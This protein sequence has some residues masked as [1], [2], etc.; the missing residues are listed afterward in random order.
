M[1][2]T[3]EQKDQFYKEGVSRF[4]QDRVD[5]F[6]KQDKDDYHRIGTA[7]SNETGHRPY[8]SQSTNAAEQE[9]NRRADE[10]K[11]RR[12][13]DGGHPSDV[14]VRNQPSGGGGG[15][16][17]AGQQVINSWSQSDTFTNAIAE[18]N[19]ILREVQASEAARRA[20]IAAK[21]TAQAAKRDELY[22]QLKTRAG[23]STQISPDDQIIKSQVDPYRAEQER[24]RRNFISDVAEAEGPLGNIRGEERMAS[25]RTGINTANFQAD[26]QVRELSARRAEIADAFNSMRGMLT[27]DQQANLQRELDTIDNQMQQ[28]GTGM[29]SALGAGDLSLR[30]DL[31]F[32]EL[33]LRDKLGTRGLDI[34]ETLG[35]RGLDLQG[36]GQEMANRHF[37]DDLGFRVG[38]RTSYWD[39][40]R[41]G[42]F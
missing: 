39:A 21:E 16:S 7:L 22:G 34:Q 4:G 13:A 12:G 2:L 8:D 14:E 18:Q 31:G 26:A 17:A 33:D 25:E 19:R 38:D 32:S 15:A 5:T 35:T 6:L 23:Q 40:V 28:I 42:L 11:A 27:V 29:T 9:A 1:P 36:M 10:E 24:A 20:D 41:R 3:Q 37:Y 30:G